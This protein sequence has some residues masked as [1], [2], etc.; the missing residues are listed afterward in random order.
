MA[1]NKGR[2]KI[3]VPQSNK[4]K[5]QHRLKVASSNLKMIVS[6]YNAN[7]ENITLGT[8][9]VLNVPHGLDTDVA[10]RAHR[11]LTDTTTRLL[12]ITVI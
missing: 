9:L 4:K 7:Y 10:Q 1:T 5:N 6:S 12:V 2:F 8:D 3:K 11:H